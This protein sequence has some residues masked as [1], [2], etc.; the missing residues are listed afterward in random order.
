MRKPRT[1][2]ERAEAASKAK[3]FFFRRLTQLRSWEEVWSFA[4]RGPTAAE[5]GGQLYTNLAYFM[6]AGG[7]GD[8]ARD[9]EI[10][11]YGEL[12]NRLGPLKPI[13]F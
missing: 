13:G 2:A 11:A 5:P 3:A 8:A 4:N 9:D 7:A 1:R 12:K 10:A 6:R